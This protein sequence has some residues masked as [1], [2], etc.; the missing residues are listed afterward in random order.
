M[1]RDGAKLL[2]IVGQQSAERSTAKTVCFL[3]YRLKHRGKVAGRRIDNLEHL[4]GRGLLFQRLV[5]LLLEI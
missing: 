3:Q 4:G 1:E 5:K 2:S